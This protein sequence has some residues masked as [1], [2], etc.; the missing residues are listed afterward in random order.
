MAKAPISS[1]AARPCVDDQRNG[2]GPGSF[3]IDILGVA[4]LPRFHAYNSDGHG[5]RGDTSEFSQ[6]FDYTD[7]QIFGNGFDPSGL[8]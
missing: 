8:F 4:S 3:K 5:R 6:C 7:D 1:A 2:Q